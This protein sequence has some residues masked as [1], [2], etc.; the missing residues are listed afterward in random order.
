MLYYK[1]WID[2]RKYLYVKSLL[3][4]AYASYPSLIRF[5]RTC[6]PTHLTHHLYAPY[7]PCAPTRL[8]PDQEALYS[9]CLVTNTAVSVSPHENRLI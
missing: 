3:N 7:V 2:K 4:C 6:A 1:Q 8:Y 9:S 5:L